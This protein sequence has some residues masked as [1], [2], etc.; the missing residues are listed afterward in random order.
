MLLRTAVPIHELHARRGAYVRVDF[1]TQTVTVLHEIPFE[2]ATAALSRSFDHLD[3]IQAPFPRRVIGALLQALAPPAPSA[4][5]S[6]PR[7]RRVK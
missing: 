5:P 6:P 3:V 1:E 4:L 2:D 7:L